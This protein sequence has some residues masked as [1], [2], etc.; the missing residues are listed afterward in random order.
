MGSWVFDGGVINAG[1]GSQYP[2]GWSQLEA[3]VDMTGFGGF[4]RH[5]VEIKGDDFYILGGLRANNDFK[6]GTYRFSLSNNTFTNAGS[7]AYAAT[8]NH[9]SAL[10]NGD[11]YRSGG[12]RYTDAVGAFFNDQNDSYAWPPKASGG[13]GGRYDHVMVSDGNNLWLHGGFTSS[14]SLMGDLWRYNSV[15]GWVSGFSQ[16]GQL[17]AR[18]YH[19]A[20]YHDGSIYFSGGGGI[21]SQHVHFYQYI[22]A[23]DRWVTLPPIPV[24]M[25]YHIMSVIGS[26]IHVLTGNNHYRYHILSGVWEAQPPIPLARTN[27]AGQVYNGNLFV[28]GG[29]A[30]GSSIG[31]VWVFNPGS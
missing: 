10:L 2:L 27:S 5:T 11:I 8:R 6:A 14:A 13:P 9:A 30:G 26:Y 31:D 1:E 25:S 22:I 29:Y 15:D 17:P 12:V 23:E 18:G 21:A 3:A 16:S 20:I 28:F 19:R 7:H 24:G 4:Y